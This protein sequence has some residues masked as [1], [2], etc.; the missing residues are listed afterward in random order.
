VDGNVL[1]GSGATTA[2]HL[3]DPA[4][5]ALIRSF[6]SPYPWTRVFGRAVAA[7]E[8][9]VLVAAISDQTPGQIGGAVYLFEAAS[10]NLLHVF[11]NPAGA[12]VDGFGSRVLAMGGNIFV[13]APFNEAV[14]THA[15]AVY[16]FDGASGALVRTL[17]V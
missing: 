12:P 14:G 16:Q 6:T 8:H 4:T 9:D 17:L 1:V 2:A 5:G 11:F 3:F 10:G 15:G 13:G 7:F